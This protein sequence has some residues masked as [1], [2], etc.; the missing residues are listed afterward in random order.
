MASVAIEKSQAVAEGG[1]MCSPP[2]KVRGGGG[3]EGL[4]QYYTQHI[5]DLQLQA[6]QKSHNLNRLE[7]QRNDLNSKGQQRNPNPST[8]LKSL[9]LLLF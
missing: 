2:V 4:R 6:R 5:H 9:G 7:A 1:E 3:G 8:V